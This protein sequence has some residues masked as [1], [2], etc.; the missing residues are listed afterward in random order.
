MYTVQGNDHSLQ[1]G[2]QGLGCGPG[3][4]VSQAGQTK[5]K[6]EISNS[7]ANDSPQSISKPLKTRIVLYILEILVNLSCFLQFHTVLPRL[8]S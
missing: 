7:C 2:G 6:L 4:G 3:P 1:G 5:W 8:F